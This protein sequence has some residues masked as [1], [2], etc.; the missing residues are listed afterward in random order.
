MFVHSRIEI[1]IH[2]PTKRYNKENTIQHFLKKK[3]WNVC[4]QIFDNRNTKISDGKY[5]PFYFSETTTA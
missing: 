1:L 5:M 2:I 3:K 4:L